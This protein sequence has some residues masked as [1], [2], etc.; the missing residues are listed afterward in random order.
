M[1]LSSEISFPPFEFPMPR[2]V[3]YDLVH[4]QHSPTDIES[5]SICII[6]SSPNGM[7]STES[8]CGKYMKSVL[9]HEIEDLYCEYNAHGGFVFSKDS[10]ALRLQSMNRVLCWFGF[11]G[12][13]KYTCYVSKVGCSV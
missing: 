7:E 5:Y 6:A 9:F 2:A 10:I 11:R 13:V 1:P 12:G 4:P 3:H 8:D